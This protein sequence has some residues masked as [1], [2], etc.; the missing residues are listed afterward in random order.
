LAALWQAAWGEKGDTEI[1]EGTKRK[2]PDIM[3]LYND[4]NFLPSWR[5]DKYTLDGV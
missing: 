4:P 2:E 5:L 1:G 3:D